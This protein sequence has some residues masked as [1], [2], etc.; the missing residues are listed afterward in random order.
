MN[1]LRQDE[2]LIQDDKHEVNSHGLSKL[3]TM[4]TS[5]QLTDETISSVLNEHM[6]LLLVLDSHIKSA[7]E[8]HHHLRE[9]AMKVIEDNEGNSNTSLAFVNVPVVEESEVVEEEDMTFALTRPYNQRIDLNASLQNYAKLN[10][11]DLSHDLIPLMG[12]KSLM[13]KRNGH[14]IGGLGFQNDDDEELTREKVKKNASQIL[15]SIDRKNKKKQVTG[16]ANGNISIVSK[17]PH[18]S[19]SSLQKKGGIMND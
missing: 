6:N 9:E 16:Q 10:E 2:V 8:Y 4:N 3:V 18:R 5:L 15:Q 13:N 11:S 14:S 19:I 1:L 12:N 17:S 7:K